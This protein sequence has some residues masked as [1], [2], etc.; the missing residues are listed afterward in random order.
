MHADVPLM[1]SNP[2]MKWGSGLTYICNIHPTEV[3]EMINNRFKAV[4]NEQWNLVFVINKNRT[5]HKMETTNKF[6]LAYFLMNVH[7][8]DNYCHGCYM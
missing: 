2:S 6:M 4:I 3:L 5:T 8:H 1:F 7:Q